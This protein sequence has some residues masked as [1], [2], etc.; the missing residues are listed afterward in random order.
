MNVIKVIAK[1]HYGKEEF[2]LMSKRSFGFDY[3]MSLP[4][5]KRDKALKEA[6][7]TQLAEEVLSVKISDTDINI[8]QD[9]ELN[10]WDICIKL[11]E[12]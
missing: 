10:L 12:Q 8:V 11:K 4:D 1:T 2:Y 9:E 7:E 3:L 6:A 5:G